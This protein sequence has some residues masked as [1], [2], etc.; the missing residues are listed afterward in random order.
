MRKIFLSITCGLLLFLSGCLTTEHPAA[1]LEGERF[2]NGEFWRNQILI[3]LMPLWFEHV[4]DEEFGAFYLNLS[5]EWKPIPPWEKVPAMIS[6]QIFSFSTA[7][8]LSGEEKYLKVARKAADYLL[9]HGWD[10]K[11]GGWYESLTQAGAPKDTVKG[12]ASQLYSNVG[13]TQYYFV[14][15]DEQALSHVLRSIEIHK[16][17]AHDE[18]FDGYFMTL[19]RDLSVRDFIK[20]K[21]SHYGQGSIMPNLFL[22]TRDPEV[23]DYAELL[24]DLSIEHLIDPEEG[25][26]LGY[27]IGF[28]REWN[29]SPYVVEGKEGIYLG[30]VSTAALFFLRLYHLTGKE[31]YLNHGMTLGE[32]LCH[33]GWDSERGSWDYAVEK[34][35]PYQPLGIKKIYS[36]IQIYGSL[37]Q[38]QMYRVTQNDQY[39]K[40][41]RK[42]ELFYDRYL[43]DQKYGGV[44]L[45][46]SPDGT[47]IG[48]GKKAAS[49]H[50]SYHQI[51]HAWL[52]YL[53]LNLYVNRRP[54]V[55]H[56]MLNGPKKHFV[57]P[58][59]DPSVQI[60]EVR[61]NEILWDAFDPLERS[62]DLPDG[63][64]L[65]VEVTLAPRSE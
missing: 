10:K 38:L 21:H 60:Q 45:G 28:D 30:A 31:K 9:E 27:P 17:F 64:N 29:Y 49:W 58:V 54:V 7:Y 63:K 39:L 46:V 41:F 65:K 42:S 53:Y 32:K 50:T 47:I 23:L 14:T 11:Y 62:I 20:A 5:R 24:A 59:D 4:T 61:I 26:I 22:A 2:M 18:E 51:E 3:D 48:D 25:W 43:V 12:A 36:W 34:A 1:E 40:R 8:L 15:G 52:N 35:P 16:T 56:F 37:L 19:N 44:F 6:R 33:Y 13:L 57:F 55:L